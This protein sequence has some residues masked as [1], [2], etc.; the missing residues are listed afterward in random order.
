MQNYVCS[1]SCEKQFLNLGKFGNTT[2]ALAY[3]LD[4]HCGGTRRQCVSCKTQLISKFLSEEW[5]ICD[6]NEKEKCLNCDNQGDFKYEYPI[7]D[8]IGKNVEYIL[9]IPF[10]IP[11]K[12]FICRT[13]CNDQEYR[14]P[15]K[16]NHFKEQ[17]LAKIISENDQTQYMENFQKKLQIE[18]EIFQKKALTSHEQRMEKFQIE[19]DQEFKKANETRKE[20]L[21]RKKS[22]MENEEKGIEEQRKDLQKQKED[23]TKEDQELNAT[24]KDLEEKKDR[25]EKSVQNHQE[26]HSKLEKKLDSIQ[27]QI[28]ELKERELLKTQELEAKYSENSAIQEEIDKFEK[29]K[30]DL[31]N[32][33][34]FIE[35]QITGIIKITREKMISSTKKIVSD[36]NKIVNQELKPLIGT[37]GDHTKIE[38]PI[39]KRVYSKE[40]NDHDYFTEMVIGSPCRHKF[41]DVCIT[42]K[43]SCVVCKQSLTE[44]IKIF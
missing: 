36:T 21:D 7:R 5:K 30:Q 17:F 43:N 1:F 25:L 13:C 19:L 23:L 22:E 33:E 3:L 2:D 41:C 16:F 40:R 42:K 24:F 18:F 9:D 14:T 12:V 35:E 4:K 27:T 38:C 29:S 20:Q 39:C 10:I 26:V 32:V 15:P 37:S 31:K 8:F 44:H 34:G 11:S 28:R 6:M